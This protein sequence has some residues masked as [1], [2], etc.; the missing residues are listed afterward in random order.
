MKTLFT[1]LV[2]IIAIAFCGISYSQPIPSGNWP[3][4]TTGEATQVNFGAADTATVRLIGPFDISNCWK[5]KSVT[6]N[7]TASQPTDSV[8][9]TYNFSFIAYKHAIGSR[10]S[11]GLTAAAC[12]TQFIASLLMTD[13][14]LPK[15]S[16]GTINGLTYASLCDSQQITALLTAGVL[17]PQNN[18]ISQ[19]VTVSTTP[20]ATAMAANTKA[21]G[22]GLIHPWRKY[23]Y[24][25]LTNTTR[26]SNNA[27]P[28][29]STVSLWFSP[30]CANK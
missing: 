22:A 9:L 1:I 24:I 3:L 27:A 11:I 23:A 25:R 8:Y 6:L 20:V 5:E 17:L 2:A 28:A 30:V 7:S 19:V 13:V 26:N 29:Y 10:D 21:G 12:S 14:E 16:T 4:F 18:V 15:T